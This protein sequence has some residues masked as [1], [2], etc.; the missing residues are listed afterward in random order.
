MKYPVIYECGSD[1][2][3]AY[4]PDLPGVGITAATRD[5]ARASI[6]K[7]VEM[8]LDGM[9]EDGLPIPEPSMTE[10]IEVA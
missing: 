7:A 6:Q 2:W 5:E 1:N 4:V 9:R 3:S 10:Y 8:H